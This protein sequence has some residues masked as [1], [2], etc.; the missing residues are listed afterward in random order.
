MTLVMSARGDCRNLVSE[1][2]AAVCG[3]RKLNFH[4]Q[5]A[6]SIVL[7]SRAVYPDSLQFKLE[8]VLRSRTVVK[9]QASS[10]NFRTIQLEFRGCS[11]L[12]VTM[13]S[14]QAHSDTRDGDKG[15]S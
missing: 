15:V 9:P 7:R 14:N 2:E 11:L 12:F 8:K 6:F 13:A 1:A 3:D 4:R 5:L 10:T